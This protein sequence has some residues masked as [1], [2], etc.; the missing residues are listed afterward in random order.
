MVKPARRTLLGGV[1]GMGLGVGGA[2]GVVA[3]RAP[4]AALLPRTARDGLMGFLRLFTGARGGCVFTNEGV[5]HA[6]TDGDL[7]RPLVS[8]LS[9]LELRTRE[10]APGIFRTEQKEAMV[11][12]DPVSRAPLASWTS[13][14]TGETLIPVGYVSPVNVYHF[15]E[16][17]SYARE[18]PPVRSGRWALDWR[19]G[20]TDIWVTEIRANSFPSSITAEEFPRAWSGPTRHSIDILT[21][22]AAARD[23]AEPRLA[24]VPSTLA[25]TSDTP[26]PLWMMM[27]TRPGGVIWHGFGQK[28]ARLSDLSDAVRAPIEA[29]YP[30]FLDDPWTFDSRPWGTAAQL[31]RLRAEGRL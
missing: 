17:G 23:F 28:H 19:A 13:P 11:Y 15:D 20:A 26:W 24:S 2:P 14:L 25:M 3:A 5:I 1:A 7:L 18:L 4:A 27:G 30:G 12:L 8:Y 6:K 9:V 21:F 10:E 16:T 29:A 31:R 22:R